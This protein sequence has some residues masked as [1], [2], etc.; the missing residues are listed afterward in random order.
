[1]A[2]TVQSVSEELDTSKDPAVSSVTENNPD[3]EVNAEG[4]NLKQIK[5]Q[6][7]P[8]T[9]LVSG[10]ATLVTNEVINIHIHNFI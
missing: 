9:I 6:R 8:S 7:C 10:T 1:M 3:V 5:C 4:K 2:E